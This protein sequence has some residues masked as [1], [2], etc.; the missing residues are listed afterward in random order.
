MFGYKFFITPEQL[1]YQSDTLNNIYTG[2]IHICLGLDFPPEA[3]SATRILVHVVDVEDFEETVWSGRQWRVLYWGS[4]HCGQPKRTLIL[5]NMPNIHQYSLRQN[6]SLK[7]AICGCFQP[8]ENPGEGAQAQR[9]PSD[10]GKDFA[11]QEW[12]APEEIWGVS[13]LFQTRRRQ[14]FSVK[15]QRVNILGFVG[16]YSS[17]AAAQLG[18]YSTKAAIHR[19]SCMTVSQWNFR[20]TQMWISYDS[21]VL[22]NIISL[23]TFFNHL[24]MQMT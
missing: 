16:H 7:L 17:V 9:K 4:L 5:L 3:H 14:R 15:V 8:A 1:I 13:A 22:K 10:R 24:R 6:N 20:D 23:L 19:Q 12:V 2:I 18:S 11:L 21:H